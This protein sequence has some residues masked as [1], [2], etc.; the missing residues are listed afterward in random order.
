MDLLNAAH[1]PV[2]DTMDRRPA[3]LFRAEL[4]RGA[5]VIEIVAVAL[6]NVLFLLVSAVA[7]REELLDSLISE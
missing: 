2:P 5:G 6:V 1:R 4:R 3:E 7:L